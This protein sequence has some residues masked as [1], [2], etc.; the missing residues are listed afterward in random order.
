MYQPHDS[1]LNQVFCN[2]LKLFESN[3][4][5]EKAI[6]LE[7]GARCV[8]LT[9]LLHRAPSDLFIEEVDMEQGTER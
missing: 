5:K 6:L 4:F 9:S 3:R 2:D 8:Q 1:V 7:L